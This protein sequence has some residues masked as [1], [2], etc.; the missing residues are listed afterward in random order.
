MDQRVSSAIRRKTPHL[1][2]EIRERFQLRLW[3]ENNFDFDEELRGVRF[4]FRM[5]QWF[6]KE[7]TQ[8]GISN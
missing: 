2:E 5:L 8:K 1:D 6:W 7:H 3:S 4:W